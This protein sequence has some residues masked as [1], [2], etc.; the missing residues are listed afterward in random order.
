MVAENFRKVR[1]EIAESARSCG[2]DPVSVELVAVSKTFDV[3]TVQEAYGAG[4]RDFGENYAQELREKQTR[5]AE[6]P[7]RWHFIGH[8][9]TNKVKYVAPFVALIHSVDSVR[10]AEEIDRR[11]HHAGRTIDV[12]V[13]L[14]TTDEAT[15]HGVPPADAIPLV[16]ELQRLSGIRVRGLMT[17][18]P[19]TDD[20][21]ASRSCFRLTSDIARQITSLGLPGVEM[22]HLSMGMSHDFKIAIEEG[23]TIVR[24]G[25][26]IFG[27]R[28]KR[29]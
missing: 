2:R 23:S 9:Q 16:R 6:L 27:P 12:L 13:E 1:A 7:I 17:M 24:I 11:A 28:S 3:S 19:F 14:H 8:L 18:G 25:T 4:A 21:E 15:K 26:A 10:L 29:E 20:T 22:R 5:L